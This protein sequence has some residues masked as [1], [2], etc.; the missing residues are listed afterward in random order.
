MYQIDLNCD[1]GESFGAYTIGNDRKIVNHISSANIACGFHAADPV[2]MH[3]TVDAAQAAGVHIGAHPG[4]PDLMGFGRRKLEVTPAEAADYVLY[5][6]GA[7][8]A[9]AGKLSHV[10]LHGALYN[11][12]G[13]DLAMSLAICQALKNFDPDLVLL[14]LS[15]SAMIEAAKQTGMRYASEVFADRAYQDDGS[16]VPRQCEG[17]VIH[18][19]A[20]A[21][22]RVIGMVKNRTVESINGKVIPIQADSVCVH[23]DN[24]EALEFVRRLRAAFERENIAVKGL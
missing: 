12:A 2:V 22:E 21:V 23:G 19:S 24:A 18:D 20:L 13:K 16:L 17:A 1:M 8:A 6:A 11:M 15:G 10:K 14:A 9:F 7:L 3:Q 5:Q 4:F